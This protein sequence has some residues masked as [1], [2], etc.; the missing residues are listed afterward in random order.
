MRHRARPLRLEKA[1]EMSSV[2]AAHLE[3][4]DR[5]LLHKDFAA[6]ASSMTFEGSSDGARI[7][8]AVCSV[9]GGIGLVPMNGS[10]VAEHGEHTGARPGQRRAW[11]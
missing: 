6:K 2:S 9:E 8:V 10:V 5:G 4:H 3:L 7:E 11:R 1:I